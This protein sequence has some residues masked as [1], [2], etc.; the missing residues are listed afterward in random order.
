MSTNTDLYRAARDHLVAVISDY[1]KAVDTFAWPPLEGTFN[2]ATDW[3][4]VSR[5]ATTASALWIVEQD[6]GE[7]KVTFAEIADRSDR[8]A[9]WLAQLGR[10]QGRP[11]DPD[12]RQP[13]RAVGGDAR[14]RRSWARSSCR[15]R[16][17]S[18]PADLADRIEPRRRPLRDRQRRRHRRSSSE[19]AGR[20][21]AHRGRRSPSTAGVATP[22]RTA[23]P[24]RGRSPRAPTSPTRCSSTSPRGTTSKPKL[25]E[26]SQVSLSGRAHVDD[27][28]DRREAGRRAPGD[29]FAGLGEARVELFLRAVD[30]RG[31]DLRLQLRAGSTPPALLRADPPSRRHHVLRA[32]DRVAHADPVRPRRADPRRC[33]RSSARANRSTPT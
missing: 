17:R 33:A 12:A 15:P 27:G 4:D 20:L 22:T 10:R 9:T 26:H 8:V 25:V 1:D 5:A 7:Q 2:W 23:Q 11:G 31:D 14:H 21:R 28:L 13:G 32:T 29:Q 16:A 6:G 3:F 18:A 24:A 30:R 19:V